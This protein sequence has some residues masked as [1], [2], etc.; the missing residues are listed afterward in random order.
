MRE[1]AITT[2]WLKHYVSTGPVALCVLCGNSGLIDTVGRANS[3]AGVHVGR[4]SFCICP[5]G[6]AMRKSGEAL[7]PAQQDAQDETDAF[8]ARGCR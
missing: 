2:Y 3:A 4:V 6:Q 1:T 7:T 5:N 8:R